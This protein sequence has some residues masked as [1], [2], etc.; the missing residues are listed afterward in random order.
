MP[1]PTPSTYDDAN[2]IL[3]LYEIRREDRMRTARRWYTEKFAPDTMEEFRA[4]CPMGSDENAF[5][6]QVSSYYEMVASF[7]TAG[8]LNQELYFQSAGEMFLA[9]SR[10]E[11][12]LP[13]MREGFKNPAMYKNLE[14]V[15]RRY[16]EY[17]N[18]NDP[19][20]ADAFRARI[21]VLAG[22]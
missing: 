20:S 13:A 3:R 8:V 21:R 12:I 6:R 18:R 11:P 19:A 4:L 7:V 14:E 17:M 5:F 10:L 1:M 15:A 2:L 16:A 9:F 22:K